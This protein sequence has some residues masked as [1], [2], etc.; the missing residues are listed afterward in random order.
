MHPKIEDCYLY[1]RKVGVFCSNSDPAKRNQT[2]RGNPCDGGAVSWLVAEGRAIARYCKTCSE[3]DL[4]RLQE[5]HPLG[6]WHLA[7]IYH[8]DPAMPDQV[9]PRPPEL[10]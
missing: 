8:D 3:R 2:H 7:P 9:K 10:C 4:P 1:P 6:D 5:H